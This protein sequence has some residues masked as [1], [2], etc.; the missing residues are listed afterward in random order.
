MVLSQITWSCINSVK[1][2]SPH[3]KSGGPESNLA[4]IS[5]IK[6]SLFKLGDADSN[7]VV[8]NQIRQFWITSVKLGSPE[9]KLG[10]L[11]KIRWS[12][13]NSSV[14]VSNELVLS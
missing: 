7:Q 6:W 11:T 13:V 3:V 10:V 9:V 8:Q 12:W 2:S 4:F 1:L 14:S 5:Q